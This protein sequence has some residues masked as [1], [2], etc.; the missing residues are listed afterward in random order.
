M[1]GPI[2]SKSAKEVCRVLL[3]DCIYKYG[4]PR[5]L[6]MDNG[7]EFNNARLTEVLEEMKALKIN[8]RPYHPQSQG[9]VERFNQALTRF[10]RRDL[11][12]E[13]DWPS[14]LPFFY[15]T[16]NTR[17]HRSLQGKTADLFHRRPTFSLYAEPSRNNLTSEEKEF[18]MDAHLDVGE[19]DDGEASAEEGLGDEET[20][21]DSAGNK[22][23]EV[24]SFP[25]GLDAE[26]PLEV[27][28][29]TTDGRTGSSTAVQ[30]PAK[31][32]RGDPV[33]YYKAANLGGAAGTA[34]LQAQWQPGFVMG[35]HMAP[36][37]FILYYVEDM[38]S[39]SAG[40]FSA[41]HLKPRPD[42]TQ[43]YL[44][45]DRVPESW[46]CGPSNHCDRRRRK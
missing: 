44:F 6:Q 10:L 41:S 46:G 21:P 22:E 40:I 25:C 13:K 8:G 38:E 34:A 1:G 19:E 36:G 5:I 17:V 16:Y 43:S 23:K 33:Y 39:A 18:L 7:G 26:Y 4:L 12:K 20:E 31:Y 15:F 29:Q 24:P 30:L 27:Q 14:R 32:T 35:I 11:Q 3:D 37:N 2:K 28:W 9:R 45:N 42:N